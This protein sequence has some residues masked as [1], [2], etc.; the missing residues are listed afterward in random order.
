MNYIEKY[1]DL[2]ETDAEQQINKH[3]ANG[4]FI[5]D[6]GLTIVIMRKYINIEVDA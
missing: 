2:T 6:N 1:I 4:W 5:H 3:I